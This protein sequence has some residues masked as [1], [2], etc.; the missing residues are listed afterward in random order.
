VLRIRNGFNA[1]QDPDRI[2]SFWSMRIRIR[3][4]IRIQIQ[5]FDDQK[6]EK[7]YSRKKKYFLQQ[8]IFFSS[9]IVFNLSLGL[10][11][12]RLSYR[13][14]EVFIPQ[15]RTSGDLKLEFSSLLWVILALLDPDPDPYS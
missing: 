12:G 15:K 3:I 2:Q 11:K 7:I 9:K 4:R 14:A 5:G 10:S 8:K 6:L 13:T 1:D